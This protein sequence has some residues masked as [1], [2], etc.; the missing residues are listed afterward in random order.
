[1]MIW[2]GPVPHRRGRSAAEVHDEPANTTQEDLHQ[3]AQRGVVE[4]V[5]GRSVEGLVDRHRVQHNQEKT[6]ATPDPKNRAMLA[7]AR[8]DA[9]RY[10]ARKENAAGP[11]I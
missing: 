4:E 1:M 5:A 3:C 6:D 8:Y 2:K 11:A 9:R 10:H 7:A